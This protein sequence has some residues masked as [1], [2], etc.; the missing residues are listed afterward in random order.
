MSIAPAGPAKNRPHAFLMVPDAIRAMA[1]WLIQQCVGGNGIGGFVTLA[2]ANMLNHVTQLNTHPSNIYPDSSTFLT[3]TIGGLD[4]IRFLPGDTDPLLPLAFAGYM[5][6]QG[7]SKP[8]DSADRQIATIAAVY[9]SALAVEMES[10][11]NIMWW[12]DQPSQTTDDMTYACETDLGSPSI[13][14]CTQIEWNQLG[15]ASINPP[16]DTVTVGPGIVQF[17]HSSKHE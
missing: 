17:F 9:W 10:G 11:G 5:A 15:P 7:Q 6:M 8:P 16:S 12:D 14:D 4:S 3:M 1:L 13:T 2:F